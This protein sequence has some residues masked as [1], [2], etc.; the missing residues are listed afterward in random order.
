MRRARPVVDP[1]SFEILRAALASAPAGLLRVGPPASAAALSEAEARL[2]RPLPAAYAAFLRS[3]N[4]AH[5][6]HEAMVLC[7]VGLDADHRLVE[8][9]LGPVAAPRRPEDVIFAETTGGD[10]W[11]LHAA[12][13]ASEPRVFRLLAGS[14]ERWLAGATFP[15]WLDATLA[16]ESILYDAE[17]EFFAEAFEPGGEELTPAFARRRAERALKKDPDSSESHHDLGVAWRR[18]GRLALARDAFAQATTLDPENPWPPFDLGRVLL[19]LRRPAEAAAAFAKSA[20]AGAGPEGGRFLAWAARAAREAGLGDQARS[21]EQRALDLD[22]GLPQALRRAALAAAEEADPAA[23]EEANA[24]AALFDP[25]R[26]RLPVV[27]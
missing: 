3:F 18:L 10:R 27:R 23:A 21:F 5:L 4:G 8:A 17:G 16:R 14:D 7:G 24:L 12:E 20:G 9:N 6:F 22:P 1:F 25:T 13:R 26:R 19:A 2:G 11:V 15:R